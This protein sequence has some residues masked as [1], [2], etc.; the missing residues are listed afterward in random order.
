M[1]LEHRAPARSE[2]GRDGE[3]RGGGA[4]GGTDAVQ[5]QRVDAGER[6]AS[7]L[8]LH[9]GRGEAQLPPELSSVDHAPADAVGPREQRLG[10]DEVAR[11]EGG[12]YGRA[13]Y[14]RARMHHRRHVFDLVSVALDQLLE[15][16][17]IAGAL[18]SET[19][20][21]AA[22]KPALPDPI[23]K[24]LPDESFTPGSP[25]QPSRT[26]PAPS[27]PSTPPAHPS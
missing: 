24:P 6:G 16:G 17:E 4:G 23:R 13:G 27:S 20:V 12:A 14:P 7:V 25:A 15:Q 22:Q 1:H 9:V 2:G 11:G 3:A 21:L 8:E 10:R 5:L 19:K 18:R 26:P